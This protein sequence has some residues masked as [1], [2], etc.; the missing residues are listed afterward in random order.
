MLI[1]TI[2]GIILLVFEMVRT[3]MPVMALRNIS[4]LKLMITHS[5]GYEGCMKIDLKR[6]DERKYRL[7]SD[8]EAYLT[9]EK[10]WIYIHTPYKQKLFPLKRYRLENGMSVKVKRV[11]PAFVLTSLYVAAVLM[12]TMIGKPFIKE[13]TAAAFVTSTIPVNL[14]HEN[15]S[16]ID[17]SKYQGVKNYLVVGTDQRKGQT[18]AHADVILLLSYNEKTNRIRICSVLRDVYAVM[19]DK[20]VLTIDDLDP[21]LPNY[22]ILSKNVS[23]SQW[24]KAKLNFA[25]NLQYIDDEKHTSEEYFAEGLNS[26][27]NTVEYMFRVPIDGI[28]C[29]TWSEFIRFIDEFGGVEIEITDDML[30]SGVEG[31]H[32]IGI[33]AV[34]DD[35]NALYG[36]KDHIDHAGNQLLNGNMALAYVRLRYIDSSTNSDVERQKQRV[37]N[38]ISAFI[39]QKCIEILKAVDSEKISELTQ[40]LYSSLSKEQTEEL[41]D[42]VL[43]IPTV[44]IKGTLPYDFHNITIDEV[45]YIGVDGKNEPR[46]EVQTMELLG[47]E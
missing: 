36:Y 40:G 17:M 7:S 20:S 3:L 19:R 16:S 28:V 46:M 15:I 35:Q 8:T 14:T 13:R 2:A 47:I 45:Q 34:L 25:V 42:T 1:I 22:Q 39:S 43:S 41:I 29:F 6:G 23:D 9:R 37:R 44:D 10:I 4:K 31:D 26:L 24:I 30:V 12:F 38:F 5:D 11:K 21:S 32:E 18:T 27:V 33:N